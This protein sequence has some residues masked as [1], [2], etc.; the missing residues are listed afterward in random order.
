MMQWLRRNAEASANLFV[1]NAT[2]PAQ[3]SRVHPNNRDSWHKLHMD[4]Q[5][6]CRVV[7]SWSGLQLRAESCR[8]P[9]SLLLADS[10]CAC[11]W[12]AQGS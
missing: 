9:C 1:V 3:V 10:G 4:A 12:P 2:T 11:R 6:C 5:D 7:S 8:L